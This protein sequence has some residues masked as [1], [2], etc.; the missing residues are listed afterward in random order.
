MKLI[1]VILILF[2]L[3]VS[4]NG[5]TELKDTTEDSKKTAKVISFLIDNF[6]LT[7]DQANVLVDL[8]PKE[9]IFF[10]LVLQNKSRIKIHSVKDIEEEFLIVN[11]LKWKRRG[12]NTLGRFGPKSQGIHQENIPMNAQRIPLKEIISVVEIKENSGG[13]LLK[14]SLIGLAAAAGMYYFL[15][16]N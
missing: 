14:Q 12:P 11:T 2:T 16:A 9:Y 1:Q 6:N 15:F 3:F 8:R 4:L 5:K 7:K 10:E 13:N